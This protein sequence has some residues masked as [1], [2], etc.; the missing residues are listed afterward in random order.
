MEMGLLTDTNVKYGEYKIQTLKEMIYLAPQNVRFG[1]LCQR[2]VLRIQYFWTKFWNWKIAG[3]NL[4]F[5]SLL[6]SNG[7]STE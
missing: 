1:V 7:L 5:Y 2:L 3:P 4:S 6:A